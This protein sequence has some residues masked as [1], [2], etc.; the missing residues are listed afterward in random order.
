MSEPFITYDTHTQAYIAKN[1]Q[2]ISKA[3]RADNW[4]F[5]PASNDW[6]TSNPYVAKNLRALMNARTRKVLEADL[7][8][9]NES[10]HHSL[11][12]LPGCTF[13][14]D[15][16]SVAECDFI[17]AENEARDRAK[18]MSEIKCAA[19]GEKYSKSTVHD[20]PNSYEKWQEEQ[21]Y[22]SKHGYE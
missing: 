15:E 7:K 1:A 11:P 22:W 16:P 2:A 9:R 13:S 14:L 3:L 5:N 12:I 19:C 20:C 4:S 18:Q 21:A 8:K 17:H 6:F 10:T